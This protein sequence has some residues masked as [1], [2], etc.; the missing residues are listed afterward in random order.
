MDAAD[1]GA[2][3]LVPV[4]RVLLL[5][6]VLLKLPVQLA[7]I[8]GGDLS[9]R[10][11]PQAGLDVPLNVSPISLQSGGPHRGGGVLLQPAVQPLTQRHFTLLP[12]IHIPVLLDVPVK[13]CQQFLLTSGG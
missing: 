5:A 7:D 9:H 10:L 13:L 12:Q 8:L 2:G 4:L 11:V 3:Q 1:G 6:A